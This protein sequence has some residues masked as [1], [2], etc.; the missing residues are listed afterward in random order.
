MQKCWRCHSQSAQKPPINR[1]SVK[2]PCSG[3][4]SMGTVSTSESEQDTRRITDR[5]ESMILQ[6][7]LKST[8]IEKVCFYGK[9][10]SRDRN[11][12]FTKQVEAYRKFV[13][14][15]SGLTPEPSKDRMIAIPV[16]DDMDYED[17]TIYVESFL[18]RKK[19]LAEMDLPYY[20]FPEQG[21]IMHMDKE[22]TDRWLE[23]M[24]NLGKAVPQSYAYEFSE[25][26]KILGCDV[27]LGNLSEQGRYEFA[28]AILYELTF[29]GFTRE[30][31][32]ERREE[33]DESI[34]ETEELMKLPKEEQEKHLVSIDDLMEE[35]GI[36]D[37][38]TQEEKD[39]D[40]LMMYR[41]VLWNN[42][43]RYKTLKAYQY[44]RSGLDD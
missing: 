34:R 25:W 14:M 38:R 28:A 7:F 41:R 21:M 16:I 39:T 40:M 10:L 6:E 24:G 32:D 18:Y 4:T 12:D 13:L 30:S 42:M 22:E 19:D 43:A 44:Q 35:L 36:E 26:E 5:E 11:V 8:D 3:V 37:T 33:L 27:W 2:S 1:V 15:L 31:Q 29:N 20:E 17:Q 23:I 9:V